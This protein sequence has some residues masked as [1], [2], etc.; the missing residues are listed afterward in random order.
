MGVRGL[1][2]GA[3]AGAGAEVGGR[4]GEGEGEGAVKDLRPQLVCDTRAGYL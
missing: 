2:E 3:G 4:A 1:G